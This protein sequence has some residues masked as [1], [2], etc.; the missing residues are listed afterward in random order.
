MRPRDPLPW[1]RPVHCTS[2]VQVLSHQPSCPHG[3][4]RS[5]C[6]C[7]IHL[8]TCVSSAGLPSALL[9]SCRCRVSLSF[10]FL[11]CHICHSPWRLPLQSSRGRF[12][13]DSP[14]P[15]GLAGRRPPQ[16]RPLP[17]LGYAVPPFMGVSVT[18]VIKQDPGDIGSPFMM[19]TEMAFPGPSFA[20][21]GRKHD[22]P[23]GSLQPSFSY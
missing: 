11:W 16:Q 21:K 19:S 2:R 20:P 14:S 6:W 15:L 18:G 3:T 17:C 12:L 9:W 13:S 22:N 4:P 7:K 1:G 5:T 8:I 23:T 10:P